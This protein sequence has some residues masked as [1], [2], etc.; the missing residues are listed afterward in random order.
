MRA[1]QHLWDRICM[2][3]LWDRCSSPHVIIYRSMR[4]LEKCVFSL[5]T[6][7]LYCACVPCFPHLVMIWA[8]CISLLVWIQKQMNKDEQSL[9]ASPGVAR[10]GHTKLHFWCPR[11][12]H[13]DSHSGCTILYSRHQSK[14]FLSHTLLQTFIVRNF[15]HQNL[16]T[17]VREKSQNV[18]ISIVLMPEDI[19]H[20]KL[21]TVLCFLFWEIS[22]Q[23]A[24]LLTGNF[25]LKASNFVSK[26][27]MSIQE[28][29]ME[30][31]TTKNRCTIK[32]Q[33]ICRKIWPR[34]PRDEPM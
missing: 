28:G 21:I 23:S 27:K 10:L 4:F 3:P 6:S 5:Q 33:D 18:L 2:L 32:L 16:S 13:T 12:L 15:L 9:C 31:K 30:R 20:F 29:T 7:K 25:M 14:V 26:G 8:G 19:V 22:V 34:R 1:G 11:N 17:G 24:P